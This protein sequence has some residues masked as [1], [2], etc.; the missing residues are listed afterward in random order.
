MRGRFKFV[1]I[2][3]NKRPQFCTVSVGIGESIKKYKQKYV[4]AP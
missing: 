2:N 1:E 4:K 3:I